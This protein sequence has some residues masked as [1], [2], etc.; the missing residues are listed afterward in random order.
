[1]TS[2]LPFD[3]LR[4]FAEIARGAS[5]AEAAERL[6]VTP[7][8]VSQ[9]IAAL[10]VHLGRTLV[11]R[12]GRKLVPTSD[13]LALYEQ[14]H[15]HLGAIEDALAPKGRD[16]V[17]RLHATP[18]FA[19]AWLMPRLE[20]IRTLAAPFAVDLVTAATPFEETR[21]WTAS[22]IAIRYGASFAADLMATPLVP[23]EI[24]LVASTARTTDNPAALLRS[25]PLICQP[26][27]EE[28]PVWLEALTVSPEA[29]A[30]G[31]RVSDDAASLRA[32]E[33]G[34]GIASVRAC[35]VGGRP[36]LRVLARRTAPGNA[37]Y[38][39]VTRRADR[40]AAPVRRLHDWA[41]SLT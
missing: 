2:R 4:T 39:L 23:S 22:D 17:L 20:A 21:G 30:W 38:H 35:N 6:N 10:E 9:R 34:H 27:L 26:G 37:T 40:G 19:D 25:Q 36:G 13:G 33:L 29:V 41:R 3:A 18:A 14:V 12:R 1:M 24:A 7:G 32:A 16:R 15:P 31:P 8:A 11:T 28:W 5:A